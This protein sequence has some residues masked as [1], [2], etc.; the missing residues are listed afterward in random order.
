MSGVISA[1]M[2]IAPIAGLAFGGP[3]GFAALGGMG[4]FG[5]ALNIFSTVAPLLMGGDDRP[6]AA[7][8]PD[9]PEVGEAPG[10]TSEQIAAQEQEEARSRA[11]RRKSSSQSDQISRISKS[12]DTEKTVTT[13][14]GE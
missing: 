2:K 14:L 3:A 4:S 13:L 10:P 11:L 5:T 12:E 9:A 6:S 8:G 7:Q 1:A